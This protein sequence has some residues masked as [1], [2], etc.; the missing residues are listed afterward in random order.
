MMIGSQWWCLRRATVEAV[1]A[2]CRA[3]P[4]VIRFF[5]TT[6]IPD[7]TFFQTLVRHLVPE[8]EIRS[9]TLTFL[10]FTDYGVPVTF[11]NDH[12]DLLVSQNHLF[13]RKISPDATELKA[14]LG[15]LY[16]DATARFAISDEGRPLFAFL[17]GRG[18]VGR[19]FAPRFWE[20]CSTIGRG[21]ELMLVACRKRH[22]GKRLAERVR[23]A[24]NLPALDYIF[25]E[26]AAN[27]PDLGG[28]QSTVG[29]RTRHR[30][31]LMRMLFD[32][33]GT[34]R[35]LVCLDPA[36]IELMRDFAADR[37]TTRI[38]EIDCA[39]SDAFLAGHACRTGLAAPETPAEVLKSLLHTLRHD[40]RF[41]SDRMRDANFPTFLRIDEAAGLE[42][43]A[44]PLAAFLDVPVA[45]A[46]ALL[47]A[48]LFED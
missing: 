18:R 16:C 40:I 25:D 26:E 11:C 10:L 2:F 14:R 34:N 38:L 4:E 46:R 1:L 32:Y 19:R 36:G 15:A 33:Y 12:Y 48:D 20:A 13:A 24:S 3:R 22:V 47:G 30:R 21:R 29:K 8:A 43:N 35:L 31:A 5:R 45:Q 27:L 23:Q 6:W 41:E 37:C 17:T 44:I 28:I 9:R 42:E 39:F 7:E